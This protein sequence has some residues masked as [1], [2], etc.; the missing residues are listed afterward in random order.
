V[1]RTSA[2]FPACVARLACVAS[3]AYAASCAA[4]NDERFADRGG[5]GT[6]VPNGNPSAPAPPRGEVFGHS[7]NTLY[8]VDTTTRAVS[9]VGYFVGCSHVADIALD[10]QSNMY[11]STGSEL[12]LIENNTARC[13]RIAAGALPNSLSFVPEGTLGSS[14]VLVGYVGADYVRID[15]KTGTTMKIGELGA[16]FESSGD[17]VAAKDGKT[18]L[19]VKGPECADCLVEVDPKT[20][21]MTKNWGSLGSTDAYGLA[22]WGGEIYAFT[23]GGNVILVTLAGDKLETTKLSVPNAPTGLAFRG[24][25]STTSA[26]TGPIR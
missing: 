19:T 2:P 8:R 1:L 5:D 3:V 16:G 20:G 25:G 14:E 11:A 12:Y 26:P 13:T 15:P 24:A 4:S 21:K 18:F 9:E 6:F 23:N 7:D 10:S 22:F 17:L